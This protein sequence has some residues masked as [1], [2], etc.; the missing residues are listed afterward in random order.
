MGL[1]ASNKVANTN[2]QPKQEKVKSEFDKRVQI[3]LKK[4][5]SSAKEKSK[6]ERVN[7]FN[8]VLLRSGRINKA[9]AATRDVFKRFDVDNSGTM[10]HDE[11]QAALDILGNKM[12]KEELETVFH[13]ADLYDN[14]Q[15]TEKEF[16]V[17]LLLGYILDDLKLKQDTELPNDPESPAISTEETQE[18]QEE[19]QAGT[20]T[21]KSTD[22]FYGHAKELQWAF[23]N[24][25]GCYLLFDVDASGDLSRDEVMKQLQ[26]K[27]GVFA[28]AAAASMLSEERW[29]EL[30]WDGDGEIT[31]R[32]FVWAFQTW[33]ATDQE[34]K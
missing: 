20:I 18:T 3:A 5:Q 15:L 13:E 26:T 19:R 24:I 33:I 16:I 6:S 31:F 14:N 8:Q 23:N 1:C 22:T 28:D 27:S 7:S 21:R 9:F 12:S 17:C 11:L 29:K 30:D 4:F 2:I 32:E 10:D 25:T 34:E